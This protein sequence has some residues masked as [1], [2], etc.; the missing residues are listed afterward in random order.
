MAI[1]KCD[2]CKHFRNV[3]KSQENIRIQRARMVGWKAER[4][5]IDLLDARLDFLENELYSI[6]SAKCECVEIRQL[7]LL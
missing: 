3:L 7:P 6:S 2:R 1:V 5:Y 4:H